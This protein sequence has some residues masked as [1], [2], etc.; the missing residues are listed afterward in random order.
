MHSWFNTL[1]QK[2][3]DL[4]GVEPIQGDVLVCRQSRAIRSTC[5]WLLSLLLLLL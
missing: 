5:I 4:G 3:L 2:L 1:R